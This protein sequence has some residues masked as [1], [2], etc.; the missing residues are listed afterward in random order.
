VSFLFLSLL[1]LVSPL[2]QI[3]IQAEANL[4]EPNAKF[5]LSTDRMRYASGEAI[6]LSYSVENVG[7]QPFY[8][9]PDIFPLAGWEAGVRLVLEDERGHSVGG[10]VA[11]HGPMPKGTTQNISEAIRTRW[12]LLQPG[13]FYG[14]R[15]LYEN[16]SPLPPGRYRLTGTYFSNLL[17]L[18]TAEQR[19]SV[20]QLKHPILVGDHAFNDV[21]IE[22]VK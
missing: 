6:L 9:H 11:A 18:A 7:I 2:Q 20:K 12:I 19:Q 10:S 5:V 22:V 4:G 14:M 16:A 17:E 13:S 3:Q 21:W 8:M 15:T 1:E